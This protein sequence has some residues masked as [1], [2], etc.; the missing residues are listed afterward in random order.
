MRFQYRS[1][2]VIDPEVTGLCGITTDELAAMTNPAT[3][4]RPAHAVAQPTEPHPE[5]VRAARHPERYGR[6]IGLDDSFVWAQLSETTPPV[7][8]D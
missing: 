3:F 6:V 2:S 8:V 1:C 4:D 5:N 7:Q